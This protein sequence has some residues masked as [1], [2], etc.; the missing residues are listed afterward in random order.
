MPV[1]ALPW[2]FGSR[3]I[4]W[5]FRKLQ[6][7]MY[8]L[9]LSFL[10]FLGFLFIFSGRIS[11]IENAVLRFASLIL[12]SRQLEE[13]LM[14]EDGAMAP[15]TSQ[16]WIKW[17]RPHSPSDVSSE[18]PIVREGMRKLLPLSHLPK[19]VRLKRIK[20]LQKTHPDRIRMLWETSAPNFLVI[21]RNSLIDTGY[22][23]TVFT[24]PGSK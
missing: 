4:N 23:F 21:F 24:S 2:L 19:I 11:E 12:T 9:Y 7:L 16:T 15:L 6:T 1:V 20:D 18:N 22:I 10:L 3:L 8:L 13:R 17:D 5:K 14:R